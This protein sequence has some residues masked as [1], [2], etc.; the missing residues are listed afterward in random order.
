MI[1]LELP[2]FDVWYLG[3]GHRSCSNWAVSTLPA[4]TFPRYSLRQSDFRMALLAFSQLATPFLISSSVWSQSRMWKN[5]VEG[6][7]WCT[8]QQDR[9]FVMSSSLS[10]SAIH[11]CLTT[12]TR[13]KLLL[14]LLLSSSC[15]MSFLA[16]AG[17]VSRGCIPQR[18]TLCRCGPKV[19]LFAQLQTGSSIS[20][21]ILFP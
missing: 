18:S 17:K 7:S 6:I 13:K 14:L 11:P 19:L 16:L 3:W 4:T 2:Q 1:K 21:S 9:H 12:S 15:I 10:S 8:L 20:V 5:G